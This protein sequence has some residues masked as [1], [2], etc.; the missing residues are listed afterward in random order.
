[1]LTRNGA[2]KRPWR[3]VASYGAYTRAHAFS[4]EQGLRMLIGAAVREA[5]VRGL[6][7]QPLFSLYSPHGP[8]F[9]AMLRVTRSRLWPHEKYGFVGHCFLDGETQVS[10]GWEKGWVRAGGAGKGR[11]GNED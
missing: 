1:V 9:R 11:A 5:A 6:I 7:V 10:K 2:G 4:G 3:A 8:V